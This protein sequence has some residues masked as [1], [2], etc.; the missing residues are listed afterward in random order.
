MSNDRA[1]VF[2]AGPKPHWPNGDR[3]VGGGRDSGEAAGVCAV[4]AV[5]RRR[6]IG[7]NGRKGVFRVQR[8]EPQLRPD[9]LRR[10]GG[11]RSCHR[12]GRSGISGDRNRGGHPG[13]HQSLRG[14]PAGSGGVCSGSCVSPGDHRRN[15]GGL[16]ARSIAPS[17]GDR[18]S[19]SGVVPRGTIPR[20]SGET[21]P[22]WF[23]PRGRDSMEILP[24][25]SIRS[26]TTLL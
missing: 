4:F 15:P 19:G 1:L 6:R 26:P 22:G 5:S 18:D 2:R 17:G 21:F 24:C 20:G 16:Y 10:A 25:L 8:R 13:T 7:G 11:A 3:R 14:L 23:P 12:G 9:N